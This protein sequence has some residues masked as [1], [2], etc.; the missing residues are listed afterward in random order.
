MPRNKENTFV[1]NGPQMC[2]KLGLPPLLTK[3]H[4]LTSNTEIC[5]KNI[6]KRCVHKDKEIPETIHW[7]DF[8][9]LFI[10]LPPFGGLSALSCLKILLHYIIPMPGFPAGIGGISSLIFAT[11]DSVVR[12]VLATL[13]AFCNALL[14]TFAGS[15]IPASTI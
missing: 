4:C 5:R 6:A 15:S 11:T 2:C 12:S 10:L 7:H 13:V 9:Y 8:G 1:E 14:V 3:S